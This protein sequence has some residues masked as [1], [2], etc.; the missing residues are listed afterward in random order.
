MATDDRAARGEGAGNA[1]VP[2]LSAIVLGYRAEAALEPLAEG[3]H[4]DLTES[5]IDFEMVLVA[6][7]D[8]DRVDRTPEVA[9][10]FAAAHDNVLVVAEPKRGAMGWD[11]RSGLDAASGEFRIVIDGDG[12]NPTHDVLRAWELRSS[13]G[14]DVVKGRRSSRADGLTRAITSLVY[15]VAFALMFGARGIWDVNGKPKGMTRAAL[16]RMDLH[17]DDWFIDAEIVLEARRLGL[18][19]EEFPVRFEENVN[20]ASFVGWKTV[21]EFVRNMFARRFGR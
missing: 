15:N 1:R 7:F 3:L 5:G 17:A 14:A 11:M 19:L 4:A 16:E 10:A 2:E 8:G 20:R 18:R 9:R 21:A 13:S 6:N 12:Q